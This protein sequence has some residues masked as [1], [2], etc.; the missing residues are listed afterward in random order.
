MTSPAFF[1]LG[2]VFA[3]NIPAGLI[4]FLTFTATYWK[5]EGAG[6]TAC[7]KQTHTDTRAETESSKQLYGVFVVPKPEKSS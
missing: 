2:N 1:R 3:K 5:T 7:S 6:L 4:W